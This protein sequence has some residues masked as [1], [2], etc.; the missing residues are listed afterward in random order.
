MKFTTVRQLWGVDP[1]TWPVTIK[2]I[3]KNGYTAVECAPHMWDD[4][5]KQALREE[6]KKNDLK[7]VYQIHTDAYQNYPKK[8][9][10][11][12]GHVE[13]FKSQLNDAKENWGEFLLFVNCHSG[14][15]GWNREQR[16]S[17]F[18]SVLEHCSKDELVVCH[19]THR[20]RVLYNPWVTLE[21]VEKFPQLK[22]TADLS[23]WF[24]VIERKLDDEMEII[25]K[26]APH[27]HHIHGRVGHSQGPQVP[28]PNHPM[29]SEWLEAHERCWDCIWK[30]RAK[31]GAPVTY[32]EPEFGPPPYAWVTGYGAPQVNVWDIC[33]WV[34]IRETERFA[35]LFHSH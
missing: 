26:I 3:K 23:H 7:L 25:E 15:D 32:F 11:V 10:T 30:I 12:N 14:Y 13:L 35:K 27:V 17:F 9:K 34:T 33:E 24:N 1:E 22:I 6:L 16:E 4:A 5:T 28:D 31:N 21:L 20:S 2:K 18:G 29:W 19:E 8:D